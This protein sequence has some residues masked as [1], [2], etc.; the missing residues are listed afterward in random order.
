MTMSCKSQS[1][2]GP[3]LNELL[4]FEKV[5]FLHFCM[6]PACLYVH[7]MRAVPASGQ[8]RAPECLEQELQAV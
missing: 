6:S 5:C 4:L 8:K 3:K 2:P 7:H 1:S